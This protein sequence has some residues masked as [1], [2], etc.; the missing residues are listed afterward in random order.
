[1]YSL[2]ILGASGYLGT[3]VTDYF[4]NLS[5]YTVYEDSERFT[6]G[7]IPIEKYAELQNL[8]VI[9]CIGT[10]VSRGSGN[11]DYI[12]IERMTVDLVNA[13]TK[14]KNLMRYIHLG[15]IYEL[16]HIDDVEFRNDA[17]VQSKRNTSEFLKALASNDSRITEIYL[18]LVISATLPK[19]RMYTD[20]IC[21]LLDNKAF[22]FQLPLYPALS[23]SKIGFLTTLNQII[24]GNKKIT[25][26]SIVIQPLHELTNLE[27]GHVI[28]GI[29]EE[30]TGNSSGSLLISD[31]SKSVIQKELSIIDLFSGQDIFVLRVSSVDDIKSDLRDLVS[32]LIE[33][34]A[35]F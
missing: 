29:L 24:D 16:L 13:F 19:G 9:N 15:S 26:N 5:N 14:F 31:L 18:P 34:A 10:G 7:S 23:I 2:I 1:M 20:L 33:N 30:L 6:E 11:Q 21:D 12:A 25:A 32:N 35:G 8:I 27:I 3:I 22:T 4:K 28:A 17:Y